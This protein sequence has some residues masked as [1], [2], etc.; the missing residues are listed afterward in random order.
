MYQ[1][2]HGRFA[3]DENH[4]VPNVEG[5]IVALSAGSARDR[6]VAAEMRPADEAG[7]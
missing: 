2:S 1:P 6:A 3:L 7:R 5:V 4:S